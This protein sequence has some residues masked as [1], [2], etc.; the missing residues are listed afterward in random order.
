MLHIHTR[1]ENTSTLL[2][3]FTLFIYAPHHSPPLTWLALHS[4][5]SLH[6]SVGFC[7]GTLPVN[8]LDFNHSIVLSYPF[9]TTL[10][11][12]TVFSTVHSA[13]FLHRCDVF[14][15][16]SLYHPFLLS[17][18]PYSPLTVPSFWNMFV[19]VCV[20][21]CVCVRGRE[22]EREREQI[23]PVFVFVPLSHMRKNM[24]LLSLWTWLTSLNMMFCS[25][26]N[27]TV[28]DKIPFF[29]MAE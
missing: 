8:I 29:F 20:C 12:S 10:C 19:C 15:Y 26:I 23:M 22:R 11:C 21:V 27:L 18:I 24:R 4:C 28:K 5:P 3:S 9:P 16:Y 25:Y 17:F 7:L 1:V 13:I 6:H 2:S 14:Q